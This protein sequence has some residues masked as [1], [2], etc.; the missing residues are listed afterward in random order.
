MRPLP[1]SL[2]SLGLGL[3]T[4]LLLAGCGH[5]APPQASSPPPAEVSVVTLATVPVPLSSDLPG[6]TSPYRIAE[7]RPQVNGV[8]QKRLFEEGAE[9]TV[10]QPLYQIDP[11]PYEAALASAAAAQARAEATLTSARFLAQRN[12]PL[13]KAGAVSQ[14]EYDDAVSAQKQAEADI[15]SAK[16]NVATAQINL[17]YTKITSPIAGRTGRSAVTEGALVTANQTTSL[18][19]VQQLDPIYVDIVQPSAQLLRLRYALAS[20]AIKSDD[21]DKMQAETK[22]LLEDG[23]AYPLPGKLQ[24]AEVTVDEGTGSLTLRALFPN[25]QR[26]LLPGMYVHAR[27]QEGVAQNSLLVPQRAVTYNAKGQ[28]TTLVVGPD[29]KVALRILKPDRTVGDAWLVPN[30]VDPQTGQGLQ[31]RERVIVE[32]IQKVA[33][34]AAVHATEF[35]PAPPAGS[36]PAS[37]TANPAAPQG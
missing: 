32:G 5:D 9:V 4:A 8:I 25:P 20:G 15:A 36:A 37:S 24:F 7:V 26:L 19:I 28:A 11:A 6:R 23:S 30:G 35:T 2:S 10:G 21:K 27:V 13:V 34:G 18:V 16:A 33:P 12:A 29:D 31:A 22:L 14:Q 3:A 1:L 17:G